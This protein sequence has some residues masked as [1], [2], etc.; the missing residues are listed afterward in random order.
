M[1]KKYQ[2]YWASALSLLLLGLYQTSLYAQPTIANFIAIDSITLP[3]TTTYQTNELGKTFYGN[4]YRQS[5]VTPITVPVF[6]MKTTFS[7]LKPIKKGGGMSTKSLRLEDTTGRQYV[8][9]SIYKSGK[10]GVPEQFRGTV[11]ESILED[12]RVGLH[13]Y[14]ALPVA[15]L[16]ESIGIYHT[17]PSIFYL[18]R[19]KELGT[20]NNLFAGELYWFEERPNEGW[21]HLKSFGHTQKIIGYDKLI[22]KV[23]KS[24]KHQVDQHW[25][26]KNRLFDMLI[27]DY[28]RHDDQWRWA[29][30]P[31]TSKKRVVYRPIPR[32]RDLAFFNSGGVLPSLLSLDFVALQQPPFKEK[33]QDMQ[34]FNSIPK[35]FD[36][37]WMTELDWE[38]WQIVTKKLQAL[39]TDEVIEKAFATWPTEIYQQNGSQLIRIL[40]A[41]RQNMSQHAK[42]LYLLLAENV[43]VVGTKD[44]DFFEVSQLQNGKVEVTVHSLLTTGAK[45]QLYHR[46]F[47]PNET[48]E[49][50]LYGLDGKDKFVLSEMNKNNILIRIIGGAAEDKVSINRQFFKG[51]KVIVY[52]TVGGMQLPTHSKLKKQINHRL[53]NNTYNRHDFQYNSY[54]PLV[55][56][57]VTP[58][59]G[60]FIGGGI[61][62]NRHSFRKKPYGSKHHLFFKFSTQTD[63]LHFKYEADLT[64]RVGPFNFN[65]NITFDHPTIFNFY[66]FG[67]N[68]PIQR[69]EEKNND[70]NEQFHWVRLKR[71]KIEPLLKWTSKSQQHSTRFGPF[72]QNIIVKRR[73]DRIANKPSFF[74]NNS[75]LGNKNFVG[76][77]VSHQ[78]DSVDDLKLSGGWK[79]LLSWTHYKNLSSKRSYSRI[80]SNISHFSHLKKPFRLV[81]GSRLGFATLTNDNYYFFHNNNL[82]GNN[83]LRGFSNN[84][85]AGKS[86]AYFNTDLRIPL[87]YAKN[88]I[89]PGELG[90]SVGFDTG[91]VWYPNANEGGWKKGFSTGVWWTPYQLITVNLF[92]TKVGNGE[93]NTVTLR[94]GFFF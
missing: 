51:K 15:A 77:L 29:A 33:I 54:L 24:A 57:G 72:Y 92:Y 91:R 93:Q 86:I 6:D 84:R 78:F 38:D 36:R 43:D 66:G 67:N 37:T 21:E 74:N 11:Y 3:A 35:H 58:D 47:D 56:F 14:S 82:G 45:H 5:W 17:N 2:K 30:F 61:Q 26:L 65:P 41:R 90:V 85:Y 25:V 18:P 48:Q 87:L 89:A 22:E 7:G 55:H 81:I 79:Y 63:A 12:L 8:L 44:Q 42:D 19:Q 94:T 13:P 83:Y 9:R 50:R 27:G 1:K 49:I 73:F 69:Q 31:D 75:Y 59:D 28:D 62:L 60:F 40:K 70:L 76:F 52:D 80:E 53:G 39:L 16:A 34:R 68:T 88:R 10:K 23:Q 46:L 20:Y 71:F 64:K 4:T 32:D